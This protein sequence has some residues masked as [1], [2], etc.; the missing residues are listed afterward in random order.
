MSDDAAEVL[1]P[2]MWSGCKVEA[3]FE[4]TAN[5]TF[6]AFKQGEK[7]QLCGSHLVALFDVERFQRRRSTTID[8]ATSLAK[9]VEKTFDD[10]SRQ[11]AMF[12]LDTVTRAFEALSK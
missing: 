9:R 7:T 5:L 1:S 8:A 10:G 4:T 3:P 11:D 2:C 6:G 12:M